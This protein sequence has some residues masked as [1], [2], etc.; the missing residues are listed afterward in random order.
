MAGSPTGPWRWFATK[1]RVSSP[2]PGKSVFA[3]TARI[4]GFAGR[5]PGAVCLADRGL[6][7]RYSQWEKKL[8]QNLCTAKGM[9]RYALDHWLA[10]ILRHSDQQGWLFFGKRGGYG[11]TRYSVHI[12]AFVLIPH[13]KKSVGHQIR[14]AQ[15]RFY[16]QAGIIAANSFSTC[17]GFFSKPACTPCDMASGKMS[18]SPL[19]NPATIA[20]AT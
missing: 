8:R 18:S 10:A 16:F 3:A 6:R 4:P 13:L 14:C 1:T 17:L 5:D 7:Q 19:S 12:S 2:C 11:C 9:G 20:A 15:V